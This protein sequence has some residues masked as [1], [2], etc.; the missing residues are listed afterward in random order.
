MSHGNKA[1]GRKDHH[2]P[3]GYLRGFIDPDRSGFEKPLWHLDLS[4]MQWT[5]KSPAEV[6]WERG[7]YD[8]AGEAEGLEHPDETFAALEREYPMVR[9][10]LLRRKFKGWVR[11][12]KPFFLRYMQMMRAR[13]PLFL[14]QQTVQNESLRGA[15]VVAT[16]PSNQI[17]LD[18]YELRP[19]SKEVIRNATIGQM[20]QE[21]NKGPNWMFNFNWCLRYVVSPDAAFVTG[22]QPLVMEGPAVFNLES[23]LKNPQTLIYFPVCWQVCLIGR[24]EKFD[25]GTD[26]AETGLVARVR[27][28][29]CQSENRYIISPRPF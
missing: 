14:Q 19:F 5:E 17:M 16:G 27:Q 1:R 29:F 11:Q 18:S 8:Y 22:P 10:K 21:V 3:R 2:L 7:F 12:Q 9:E 4:S 6:G 28:L 24:L 13:S 26:K 20:Q 25:T 23:A 15:T